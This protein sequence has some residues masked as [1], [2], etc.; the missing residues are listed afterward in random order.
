MSSIFMSMN[1]REP[2]HA[3]PRR[4]SQVV[5][6]IHNVADEVWRLEQRAT[7]A[8][9]AHAKA[10]YNLEEVSKRNLVLYDDV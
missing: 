10:L 5:E 1:T 8:E 4:N 7:A 3:Q 9:Q 2:P 6:T